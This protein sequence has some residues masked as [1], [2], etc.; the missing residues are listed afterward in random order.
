[1]KSELRRITTWSEL[2]QTSN[3]DAKAL[4]EKCGVCVRQLQRFFREATGMSP[5]RWL[6]QLR[7]YQALVLLSHGMNVKEVAREL[8][9]KQRTHFSRV[10]KRFH[11]I[12]PSQVQA[13]ALSDMSLGDT[14]KSLGDTPL[15]FSFLFAHAAMPTDGNRRPTISPAPVQN[16]AM[17][18]GLMCHGIGMTR[19]LY[20]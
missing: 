17:E 12:S 9:F 1:M 6:N 15:V 7:L 8:G 11:G 18:P 19:K 4:A 20:L 3:Y 16:A 14:T 2:A 10:F 5:Q 13:T